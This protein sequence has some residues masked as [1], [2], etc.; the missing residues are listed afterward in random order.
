[1]S[2]TS[3]RAAPEQRPSVV[4]ECDSGSTVK[5][6]LDRSLVSSQ[7]QYY[8]GLIPTDLDS[9]LNLKFVLRH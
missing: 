9:T 2:F 8:I 5:S 6:P 3:A 1:M 7:L 4:R